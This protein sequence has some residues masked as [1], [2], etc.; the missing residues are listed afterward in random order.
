M[1]RRV[2]EYR[3]LIVLRRDVHDRVRYQ[4]HQREGR[5]GNAGTLHVAN[6]HRDGGSARLGGHPLGH[7]PRQLQAMHRG[8]PAVQRERH[9]PGTDRELQR[10]T[11]HG[12][13][14]EYADHGV[15]N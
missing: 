11:A 15:Q 3:Q 7:R 9:A 2:G 5:A 10:R 8:P 1:R 6:R 13:L 4:V 12:Q 14:G